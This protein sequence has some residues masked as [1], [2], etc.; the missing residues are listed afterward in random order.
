MPIKKIVKELENEQAVVACAERFGIVG[1]PTRMKICWL[2]CN[3]KELSVGDIARAL[4]VSISVVS[5]SLKRLRQNDMVKMR[6][7][8]KHVFYELSDNEFN[9]MI[10]KSLGELEV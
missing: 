9:T 10:R 8:C 1:D 7:E 2:L 3:H 5:H 4:D 6:K